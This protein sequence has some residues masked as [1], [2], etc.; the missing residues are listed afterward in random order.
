LNIRTKEASRRAIC[1]AFAALAALSGPFN[2]VFC[3]S[4]I[5][6][7]LTVLDPLPLINFPA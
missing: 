3:E 2:D 5:S 4:E 1:A 6:N 7:A